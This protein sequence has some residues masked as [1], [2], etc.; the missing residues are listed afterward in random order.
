VEMTK[1]CWSVF[2]S[3]IQAL[4]LHV[5]QCL[6]QCIQ[7]KYQIF[8]YAS[9]FYTFTICPS[10]QQYQCWNYTALNLSVGDFLFS[11]KSFFEAVSFWITWRQ[12]K[13]LM[14]VLKLLSKTYFKQ[15]FQAWQKHVEN[16]KASLGV[17][18]VNK[19]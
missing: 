19:F 3:A 8:G 10:T 1:P 17:I 2:L 12:S 16:H 5:L 18:T 9:E 11:A 14:T 13:N 7:H 4:S 15:S 6:W